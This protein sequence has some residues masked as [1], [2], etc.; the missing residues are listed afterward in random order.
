MVLVCAESLPLYLV[1]DPDSR[2]PPVLHSHFLS[3]MKSSLQAFGAKRGHVTRPDEGDCL[4][5]SATEIEL[6]V[7]M[8]PGR[9]DESQ[10]GTFCGSYQKRQDFS[11]VVAQW[12]GC[13][14]G[15]VEAILH[16]RGEVFPG[17][18]PTQGITE[19]GDGQRHIPGYITST[20]G[21]PFLK[22]ALL[23]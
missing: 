20:W 11:A 15:T 8:R 13:V 5:P 10:S 16:G 3:F 14:P 9:T 23:K 17:Q 22:A 12:A 4:F 6:G 1:T 19:T 7:G 2:E 21:H 18:Q